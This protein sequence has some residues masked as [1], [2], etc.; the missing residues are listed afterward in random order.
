[1]IVKRSLV[2]EIPYNK[3]NVIKYKSPNNLLKHARVDKDCSGLMLVSRGK[4][5]LIGYIGWQGDMIIALEVSEDYRGLGY[6]DY[7]LKTAIKSGC[8]KLTV[9][10]K[11]LRA[12]NL[13]QKNGFKII[14]KT[15]SRLLMSL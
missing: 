11:N 15:G 8:T 2:E 13:Y 10:E 4:K 5:D 1:M 7:L 3:E 12:I 9:S 6:G 14:N